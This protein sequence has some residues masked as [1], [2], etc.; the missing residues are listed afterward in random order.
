M[1]FIALIK[2]ELIKLFSHKSTIVIIAIILAVT[3]LWALID[4]SDFE[5]LVSG[6]EDDDSNLPQTGCYIDSAKKEFEE[7]KLR[8]ENAGVIEGD[9]RAD[10]YIALQDY[11]NQYYNC[12]DAIA[13]LKDPENNSPSMDFEYKEP[14]ESERETL[15]KEYEA[16]AESFRVSIDRF[17]ELIETNDYTSVLEDNSASA[18]ISIKAAL[19]WAKAFRSRL[20]SQNATAEELE[21][22]DLFAED[23]EKY[24]GF[25]RDAYASGIKN[26]LKGD[27]V[28]HKEAHALSKT[29]SSLPSSSFSDIIG[30]DS[31]MGEYLPQSSSVKDKAAFEEELHHYQL[32]DADPEHETYTEYLES[33]RE[34][35]VAPLQ[36]AA[37]VAYAFENGVSE[38]TCSDSTRN[39]YRGILT[40]SLFEFIA[41]FGIFIAGNIVSSEYSR[42]TINMLVIRPVSR[43][44]IL[45][46]KYAACLITVYGVAAAG[47]L[48]GWIFC[49]FRYGFADYFQ[50]YLWFN[51]ESVSSV[52]YIV[53]FLGRALLGSIGF[54]FLTTLAFGFSNL[55]KNTAVSIII[56]AI[57]YT[58]ASAA[59]MIISLISETFATYWPFTYVEFWLCVYNKVP[60][61]SQGDGLADVMA[62]LGMGAEY[63]LLYGAIVLIAFTAL[64]YFSSLILFKRRDI[65]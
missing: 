55:T 40:F 25:V 1:K 43:S 22:F 21:V 19:E 8:A 47:L 33:V 39:A 26:G 64:T 53:W 63:N 36:N 2:N 17:W 60:I 30:G 51:G 52:P 61:L 12:L 42:K 54:L 6:F 29:L 58:F 65:K 24:A 45:L 9:W 16:N 10:Y 62:M 56:P 46:S 18:E 13:Y 32:I 41:L 57:S 7:N 28:V 3:M 15:I 34:D 35:F 38:M 49:G 11:T 27:P 44:K 4:T 37:I 50:P 14:E 31:F 59:N 5:A 23:I 20:E 48:I